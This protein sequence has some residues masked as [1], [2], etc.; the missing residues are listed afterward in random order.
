[1][2]RVNLSVP[3]DL[4]AAVRAAGQDLNLSGALQDALRARLDCRHAA[5]WRCV[6]CCEPV[7]PSSFVD[8]AEGRLFGDLRARLE[9]LVRRGGT[10]EGAARVMSDVFRRHQVTAALGAV[11]LAPSRAERRAAK[12]TELPREADSRRRHPTALPHPP[13]PA[14][15]AA[16]IPTEVTA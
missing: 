9:P 4:L 6:E 1:M 12:V 14:A 3:D 5:G 15:P 13:T 2:A 16:P 7:D 11:E 10:A 8:Q